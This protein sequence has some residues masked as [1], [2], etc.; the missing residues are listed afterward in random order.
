MYTNF[1]VAKILS[2][3]PSEVS[4]IAWSNGNYS[5]LHLMPVTLL[6]RRCYCL[7]QFWDSSRSA[8]PAYRTCS[9]ASWHRNHQATVFTVIPDTRVAHFMLLA[10]AILWNGD[11][12]ILDV[13]WECHS[14]GFEDGSSSPCKPCRIYP[15]CSHQRRTNIDAQKD[16]GGLF[17]HQPK[18]R[19]TSYLWIIWH[20]LKS[21]LIQSQLPSGDAV[22]FKA[23]SYHPPF[24]G[25]LARLSPG[26]NQRLATSCLQIF[27]FL[28]NA[29]PLRRCR[30]WTSSGA[31]TYHWVIWSRSELPR[32]YKL[33]VVGHDY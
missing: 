32:N 20:L 15:Q 1:T 27:L 23:R 14:H 16:L 10:S 30:R 21:N 13:L 17:H 31:N 8:P 2:R 26:I 24:F 6:G 11:W 28:R 22:H 9:S 18:V 33:G 25:G 7:R 12:P 29:G 19:L 3:V 4:A 5:Q